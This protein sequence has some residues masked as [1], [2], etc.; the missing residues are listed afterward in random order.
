VLSLGGTPAASRT[1][2]LAGNSVPSTTVVHFGICRRH[3]KF[4][5][6]LMMSCRV[7]SATFWLAIAASE[8]NNII[9]NIIHKLLFNVK[10]F[11]R[12]RPRFA[13]FVTVGP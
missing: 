4:L 7:R 10:L 5:A 9:S 1:S 13:L 12:Q 11:G 2:G 6:A 3:L 8:F